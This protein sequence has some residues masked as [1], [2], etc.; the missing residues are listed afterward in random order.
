MKIFIYKTI[1]IFFVSLIFFKLTFINT[2]NE[3]E[4]KIFTIFSKEKIAY[5]KEKLRKELN[6]SL[7]KD[8]ILSEK[9]AELIRKFIDKIKSE[10]YK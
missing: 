3:Y 7:K 1:I 8:K 2:I 10:L 9:D 6:N 4:K 5:T